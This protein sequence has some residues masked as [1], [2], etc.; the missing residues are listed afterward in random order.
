MK[1]DH[2]FQQFH[3]TMMFG[4]ILVG[5]TL[6]ILLPKEKVSQNEKRNLTSF[7]VFSVESFLNKSYSK[8]VDLYVN[9]AFPYRE[10]FIQLNSIY[11]NAKGIRE[12][13]DEIQI[14]KIQ[15]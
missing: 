4:I 13:S 6:L 8:Q 1:N 5:F 10:E 15:K 7:P 2:L 11:D 3:I 9:D 12:G 14:Y